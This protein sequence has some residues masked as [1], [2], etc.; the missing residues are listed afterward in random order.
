MI[1]QE[2]SFAATAEFSDEKRNLLSVARGSAVGCGS[3]AGRIVT[4]V[5]Q[6]DKTAANEHQAASAREFVI[7][8]EEELQ[9]FRHGILAL[10]DKNLV[11]SAVTGESKMS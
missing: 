8:M 9:K 1:P 7:K 4:D 3:A 2:H 11:S 6:E 10:M 5:E